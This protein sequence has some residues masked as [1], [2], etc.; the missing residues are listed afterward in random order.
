MGPTLWPGDTSIYARW[1]QNDNMLGSHLDMLHQTTTGRGI[2]YEKE[3]VYWVYDDSHGNICRYDFAEPHVVGGDDHSDGRIRRYTEVTVTGEIGMPSHMVIDTIGGRLYVVD[4]DN[5]RVLKVNINSGEVGNPLQPYAG[6]E[7]VEYVSMKNVQ[8]ETYISGLTKPVGIEYYQGRLLVSDFSTGEII[9]YSTTGSGP[10]ELG[11]IQTGSS[12]LMGLKVGPDERIWYTDYSGNKIVRIDPAPAGIGSGANE[13]LALCPNPSQG[14]FRL[15]CPNGEAF[16]LE[17]YD[18]EGRMLRSETDLENGSLIQV[19]FSKG[20]YMA[21]FTNGN[22]I[23][24]KKLI[25]N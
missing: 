19:P 10:L 17:L 18:I 8:W 20:V 3:N 6:E 4:T 13:L 1:H 24:T 25:I 14:A 12:G 7:L 16:K 5:D 15:S 21:R 11:R 2:A 9:M 23:I 22:H